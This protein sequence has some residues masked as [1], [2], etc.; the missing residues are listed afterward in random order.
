MMHRRSAFKKVATAFSNGGALRYSFTKLARTSSRSRKMFSALLPRTLGFAVALN[1][2]AISASS[3]QT[4]HFAEAP[5]EKSGTDVTVITE[6][7][8]AECTARLQ[9]FIEELEGLLSREHSVYP[10]QRLFK[11]YFPLQGCDPRAVLELC[12]K[13]K[14]CRDASAHPDIMVIAFD[15]QW[16]DPHSGLHVQFGIDKRTG[17]A[18]L[19]FVKVKI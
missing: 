10:I 18:R 19:P 17:E 14:Y 6:Q 1:F 2:S 16:N 12:L 4:P 3:Q 5:N 15:S 7:S 9:G 13:S 11:K 8:A